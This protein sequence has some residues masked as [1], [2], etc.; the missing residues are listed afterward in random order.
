[1][2]LAQ[3]AGRLDRIGRVA[4][5]EHVLV[6]GVQT[7]LQTRLALIP[8]PGH[9]LLRAAAL[10]G[11]TLDLALIRHLLPK[12]APS[13]LSMDE[14]LTQCVNAALLNLQYDHWQFVH[15]KFRQGIL[16]QLS[17]EER[18]GLSR[19]VAEATEYIYPEDVNYAGRLV[20]HWHQAEDVEKEY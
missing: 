14:W 18:I 15:D 6:E 10:A 7:L 1:R 16:A 3:E 8:E 2:T 20:E 9:R 11:R 13:A 12:L 17:V 5:P 19:Q 4:L